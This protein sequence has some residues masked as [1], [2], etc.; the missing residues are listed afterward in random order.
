M[1]SKAC[2]EIDSLHDGSA[3]VVQ[4]AQGYAGIP[5]IEASHG[6]SVWNIAL[7]AGGPDRVLGG[8]ANGLTACSHGD[9]IALTSGINWPGT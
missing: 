4:G 8:R 9:K 1:A 3:E 2:Q 5:Q 7:E 6:D